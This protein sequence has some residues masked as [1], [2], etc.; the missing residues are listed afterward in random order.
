MKLRHRVLVKLVEVLQADG[1]AAHVHAAGQETEAAT[2]QMILEG[3][4]YEAQ[5]YCASSSKGEYQNKA[6]SRIRTLRSDKQQQLLHS[7]QQPTHLHQGVHE[8]QPVLRTQN[9]TGGYELKPGELLLSAADLALNLFPMTPDMV[10][11]TNS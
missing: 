11:Q 4:V 2:D 6:T 5:L 8:H 3:R 1:T 10:S 7:T 9:C